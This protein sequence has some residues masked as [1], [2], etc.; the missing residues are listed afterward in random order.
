VIESQRS[1]KISG[2][3]V[4]Y[5]CAVWGCRPLS[6]Q[7]CWLDG[8]GES[9]VEIPSVSVCVC[10]GWR[11]LPGIGIVGIG[12]GCLRSIVPGYK[13]LTTGIRPRYAKAL[14]VA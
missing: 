11:R 8:G 6:E 3:V 4:V 5:V 1:L 13:V 14:Y 2:D 7:P 9:L 12:V 10:S